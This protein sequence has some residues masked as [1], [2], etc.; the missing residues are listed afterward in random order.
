MQQ[1]QLPQTM[2]PRNDYFLGKKF[3]ISY[4]CNHDLMIG[5][6]VCDI[7]GILLEVGVNDIEGLE[8]L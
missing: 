4:A 8:G 2:P 7:M 5:G 6:T 1:F 3:F